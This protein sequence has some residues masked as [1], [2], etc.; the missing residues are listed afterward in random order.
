MPPGKRWDL[1]LGQP[2]VLLARFVCL[3]SNGLVIF[4]G[5]C[6]GMSSVLSIFGCVVIGCF[7]C[8]ACY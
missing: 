5:A 2:F 8:D 6:F 3:L 4:K 1:L 7:A